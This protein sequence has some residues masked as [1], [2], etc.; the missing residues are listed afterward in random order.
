MYILA[1]NK[2]QKEVEKKIIEENFDKLK[3]KLI[4]LDEE[5]VHLKKDNLS[6]YTELK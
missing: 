4:S 2:Q 6:L 3:N 5:Y 1:D